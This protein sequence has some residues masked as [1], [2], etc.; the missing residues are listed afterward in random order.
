MIVISTTR[1]QNITE[2]LEKM[3]YFAF[4]ILVVLLTPKVSHATD[5]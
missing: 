4:T 2:K 1:F 5:A 3:T